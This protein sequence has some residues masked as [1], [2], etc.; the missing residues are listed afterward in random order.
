MTE[1]VKDLF[2][3][4]EIEVLYRSNQNLTERPTIRHAEDSYELLLSIWDM[5]KIEMI[6]Q[7]YLLLL[8]T[9]LACMCISLLSTGGINATV[10]DPRIVFA[11]ALKCKSSRIILAHNHPSGNLK[12]SSADE[13]ITDKLVA[14]GHLLEIEVQDH[15]IVTPQG[16]FS[17]AEEGL[18]KRPSVT[19]GNPR[20]GWNR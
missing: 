6:E 8:D 15:L 1:D 20:F 14:G 4:A 7:S 9:N 18:M 12:P 5:N 3:F 2:Q 17:F 13:M 19:S 16:Y 10:V 11:T